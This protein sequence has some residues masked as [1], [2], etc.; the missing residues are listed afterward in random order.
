M[1]AELQQ[2]MG[3]LA[4]RFLCARATG[5][6]RARQ[7]SAE[8]DRLDQT[9]ES[10][11]HHD[12]RATALFRSP[13]RAAAVVGRPLPVRQPH[14]DPVHTA[15]PGDG[16]PT[17]GPGGRASGIAEAAEGIEAIRDLFGPRLQF[18]LCETRDRPDIEQALRFEGATIHSIASNQRP[19]AGDRRSRSESQMIR[20]ALLRLKAHSSSLAG[21]QR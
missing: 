16:P 14:I 6:H 3:R 17:S 18:V 5:N 21:Y 1:S 10:V 7:S 2:G 12:R 15:A 19:L 11:G 8:V 13:G 9:A 4:Q 20:R